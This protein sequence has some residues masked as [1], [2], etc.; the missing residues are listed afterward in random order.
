MFSA[1]WIN[2]APQIPSTHP[3]IPGR[4]AGGTLTGIDAGRG[5]AATL[6]VL[7]HVARHLDKALG[8]PLLKATFQFGH[9]GVDFFFVISGFIILH[10]HYADIG[11]PSR[12][13]H[14]A[15]RR[16]TRVMPAYWFVLAITIL[17][18]VGHSLG[19]IPV[20]RLA[21]SIIPIPSSSVMIVGSAWTLQYEL[22]FYALFA[23]I[24]FSRRLGVAVFVMWLFVTLAAAAGGSGADFLPPP[25]HGAYNAGFFMGM[26]AAW[27]LRI[28]AL[29]KPRIIL[30]TGLGLFCAAAWLEDMDVLNGYADPARLAYGVPSTLIVLGVAELERRRTLSMPAMLKLLG[31]ASFSIYLFQFIL[32]GAGWQMLRVSRLDQTLPVIAQFGILALAAILGGV[33]AFRWIEQPL[34][35]AVRTRM[36]GVPAL[37]RAG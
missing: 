34:I 14:Y 35:H 25:F 5:I 37:A 28:R 13:V 33:A 27:G 19:G 1:E 30:A 26:A 2:P 20:R 12:L 32:I 16:F 7:Y 8:A 10:V 3:Y 24:I 21:W 36:R 23:I 11:Q 18:G 22:L 4:G 15:C 29:P 31:S 17:L 6:V 9:A